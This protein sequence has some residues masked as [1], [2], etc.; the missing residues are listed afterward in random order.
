M[1][2]YNEFISYLDASLLGKQIEILTP[3]QLSTEETELIPTNGIAPVRNP[4]R[5]A[6]ERVRHA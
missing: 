1:S 2:V 6:T 5:D 4:G 3:D